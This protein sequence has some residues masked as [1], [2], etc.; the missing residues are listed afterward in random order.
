MKICTAW[1]SGYRVSAVCM[2]NLDK[3]D[4][5]VVGQADGRQGQRAYPDPFDAEGIK[6]RSRVR[7]EFAD[8]FAVDC[9]LRGGEQHWFVNMDG[10]LLMCDIVKQKL[11]FYTS[12]SKHSSLTWRSRVN[13]S[14]RHS[15][16]FLSLRFSCGGSKNKCFSRL[17][18]PA[19][20]SRRN[21]VSTLLRNGNG[22]VRR[23]H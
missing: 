4:P 13:P 7:I 11:K 19:S 2:T 18:K 14:H 3:A 20:Q 15:S 23:E 9:C 6:R 10:S 17:M 1:R 5:V 22:A 21:A 8:D 12:Q 16:Q